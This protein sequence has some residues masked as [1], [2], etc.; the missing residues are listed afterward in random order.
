MLNIAEYLTGNIFETMTT[1][2]HNAKST[3][4]FLDMYTE[5]KR[6]K[7]APQKEPFSQVPVQKKEPFRGTCKPANSHFAKQH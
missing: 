7:K 5:S 2:R 3:G 6:F 1:Q 4:T